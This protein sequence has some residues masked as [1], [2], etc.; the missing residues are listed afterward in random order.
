MSRILDYLKGDR[1]QVCAIC[2]VNAA[3][4]QSADGA[5]ACGNCAAKVLASLGWNRAARRAAKRGK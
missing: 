2:R 5:W 4:M 3:E 1:P